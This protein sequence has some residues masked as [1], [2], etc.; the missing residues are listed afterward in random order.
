[1]KTAILKNKYIIK[2]EIKTLTG[3][4]IGGSNEGISIGKNDNPVIK[5]P[6]TKLPYIPGSSLKGKVRSLIELK[7]GTFHY[8]SRGKNVKYEASQ[9]RNAISSKLFGNVNQNEENQRPSRVIFR[10]AYLDS[11]KSDQYTE[12]KTEVVIDRITSAANPRPMERVPA[13]T[14]FK[15]SV[16][17]NDIKENEGT[18]EVSTV[19]EQLAD[20]QELDTNGLVEELLK[21]FLLLQD[22]YLGG[23]GSRGSGQV[24]INISEINRRSPAYYSGDKSA[25]D[26]KAI[27]GYKTK[28]PDLFNWQANE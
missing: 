4:H 17:V 18:E 15:F 11:T 6:I 10:D 7:H 3:L 14:I 16:I 13:E 12:T 1:M 23:H 28:F 21:G 20:N 26:K 9:N 24:D 25:E 5:H 2:G 27:E 22:D 8:N 19:V